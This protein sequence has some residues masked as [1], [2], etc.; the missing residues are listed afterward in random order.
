MIAVNY[1]VTIHILDFLGSLLSGTGQVSV[2]DNND[3]KKK[4][5]D[6]ENGLH[7]TISPLEKHKDITPRNL[8]TLFTCLHFSKMLEKIKFSN[9]KWTILFIGRTDESI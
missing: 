4:P 6:E 1:F 8:G 3:P 9:T 5:S 7:T 2:P